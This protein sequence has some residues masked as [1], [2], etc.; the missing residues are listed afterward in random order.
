MIQESLERKTKSEMP[1]TQELSFIWEAHLINFA[2]EQTTPTLLACYF[3]E[4]G[5]PPC[6]RQSWLGVE[7]VLCWEAHLGTAPFL[8]ART[9]SSPAWYLG[10]NV[11]RGCCVASLSV[12]LLWINPTFRHAHTTPRRRK[13]KKHEKTKQNKT[14][15]QQKKPLKTSTKIKKT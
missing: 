9:L 4:H 14:K 1:Q 12:A 6:S 10:V 2:V 8:R 11:W 7:A 3:Q 13:M 15:N 5:D